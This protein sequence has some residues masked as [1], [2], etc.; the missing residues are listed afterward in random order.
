[1]KVGILKPWQS[2]TLTRKHWSKSRKQLIRSRSKAKSFWNP[3]SLSA[4]YRKPKSGTGQDYRR[5]RRSPSHASYFAS[6]S[7]EKAGKGPSSGSS[8]PADIVAGCSETP[9]WSSQTA[10]V[11]RLQRAVSSDARVQAHWPVFFSEQRSVRIH[12]NREA[13]LKV[14]LPGKFTDVVS[15]VHSIAGY[16]PPSPIPETLSVFDRRVQRTAGHRRDARPQSR[17]FAL[18]IQS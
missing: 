13:S 12:S 17:L 10:L 3:R 18:A 2:E 1:M 9:G 11:A 7:I 6:K 4:S 14:M 8:G 16:K 15:I 5:R